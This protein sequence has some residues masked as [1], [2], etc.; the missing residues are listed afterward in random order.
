[1]AVESRER[2]PTSRSRWVFQISASCTRWGNRV[3]ENS[4]KAREKTDSLGTSLLRSQQGE[5]TSGR[6]HRP[7]Q[8]PDPPDSLWVTHLP[9]PSRP[10]R[11]PRPLPL[12]DAEGP[13]KNRRLEAHRRRTQPLPGV[14]SG[15]PATVAVTAILRTLRPV[16]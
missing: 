13:R 7:G 3:S 10:R 15:S 14:V 5:T 8:R 12:L 6:V 16:R 4:A 2:W 11:P 9:L 1:M